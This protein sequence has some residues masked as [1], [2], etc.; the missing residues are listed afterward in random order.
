[1]AK[2]AP[3]G[4]EPV[5]S[6]RLTQFTR[7]VIKASDPHAYRVGSVV[8]SADD[9]DEHGVSAV[10]LA[11]GASAVRGAILAVSPASPGN[12][13]AGLSRR[14]VVP[15]VKDRDYYVFV[16]DDQDQVF[17]V[18]DDGAVPGAISPSCV[19]RL[20]NFQ[21]NAEGAAEDLAATALSSATFGTGAA[22]RVL[23]LDPKTKDN[24]FHAGAVWLIKFA[25]HEL[26]SDAAPPGAGVGGASTFAELGGQPTDNPAL[27]TALTNL[28]QA[29]GAAQS[30]AESAASSASAAVEAA[31]DAVSAASTALS[32]A[33]SAAST[34][35]Y[36]A[37]LA[38]SAAGAASAAQSTA[39]TAAAK[40]DAAKTAA[41]AATAG[42]ADAQAA[43]ATA[44]GAA[45]S[46]QSS[47]SDAA[48]SASAASATASQASAKADE[49]KAAADAV[50][51]TAN[52]A[53]SAAQGAVDTANSASS[54]AASAASAAA[55]AQSTADGKYAKPAGGIPAADLSTSVQGSLGKADAAYAKPV[56]G[57]PATDLTTTAQATLGKADSAYQKPGGGVPSTDMT[58][59]VQ[60]SLGKADSSYQKPAAGIPK[61]DLV[62]SVQ[63]SL[64]SA[65]SAY[66][67][68]AGGVPSSD[69]ATG[70]QTSLGR[71]D[72]AYQK[73]AGGVP[74]ADLVTAVQTSLGKADS[75]YQL[76][77]GGVPSTDMATAVQSSLGKAD[78]AYAK[79]GTGIPASDLATAIQTS[80]GKADSAYQKPGGG[81]PEADLDTATRAKIDASSGS[82][83]PVSLSADHVLTA[84]DD[85]CIFYATTNVL[86]TVPSG[87]S[88][89][90]NVGFVC[91]PTGAITLRMSGAATHD[92]GLTG[93]VV[94]NRSTDPAGFSLV[95]ATL[96]SDTGSQDYLVSAGLAS[97]ASLV[98]AATDNTSLVQSFPT[99]ARVPY[100]MQSRVRFH[101]VSNIT[102]DPNQC[103]DG[104]LYPPGA[105]FYNNSG[106][107]KTVTLPA[108]IPQNWWMELRHESGTSFATVMAKSAGVTWTTRQ[109]GGS[110]A[111]RLTA[112]GSM[113]LVRSYAADKYEFGGS[114]WVV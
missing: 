114:D 71:A 24:G 38:S 74:K 55:T 92:G 111:L 26:A 68:P 27:A 99:F 110:D 85:N 15:A 107:N 40:A 21:A 37:S 16:A 73:P 49:A 35:N 98:G 12:A 29:A 70:V 41:D 2:N 48:A 93:D 90:P 96:P 57:I 103:V 47:A 31:G 53:L 72:S 64:T 34:A 23:G 108:G 51:G 83:T 4:F 97:F 58:T 94:K 75:A 52:D 61:T 22:C 8:S 89:K 84:A 46:A 102:L 13:Y 59:A 5:L 45:S 95:P 10:T 43:A 112:Q 113:G 81:I 44:Q 66:Q 62:T 50:A 11:D 18:A 80:L 17:R 105:V 91:P 67:K 78:A 101:L 30:T 36:A 32:T 54:A 7:Y 3:F 63:T 65:D 76:P 33:A 86:V 88:P 60:A 19:G 1:M 6:D 79:P 20:V 28:A 77:A 39:E 69:M 9:A 104:G 82:S 87:L 25:L 100:G 106:A 42:V 109:V 14:V 56:G